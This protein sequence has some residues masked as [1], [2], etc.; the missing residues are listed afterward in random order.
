VSFNVNQTWELS[1][2]GGKVGAEWAR[3]L[4]LP[5]DLVVGDGYDVGLKGER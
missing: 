4:D 1:G 5:D 3:L 2:V